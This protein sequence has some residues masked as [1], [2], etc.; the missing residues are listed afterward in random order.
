MHR[1]LDASGT[2]LNQ[3]TSSSYL[4]LETTQT[5]RASLVN[6]LRG[7]QVAFDKIDTQKNMQVL[8]LHP[9]L[10]LP[11]AFRSL[12]NP[13]FFFPVFPMPIFIVI[14]CFVF[15]VRAET[16]D[17]GNMCFQHGQDVKPQR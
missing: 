15:Q 14:Y 2:Y 9:F 6:R 12:T 5:V 16:A 7:N 13:N 10:F 1:Y 11:F 4:L 8:D 17:D 3:L